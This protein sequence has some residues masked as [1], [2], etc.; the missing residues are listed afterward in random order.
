VALVG[1]TLVWLEYR[2]VVVVGATLVWLD[3]CVSSDV[4]GR[5]RRQS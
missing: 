5:S 2:Q 4:T 1:D 3:D